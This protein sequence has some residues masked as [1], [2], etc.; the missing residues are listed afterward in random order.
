MAWFFMP[1]GT[2]RGEDI[3]RRVFIGLLIL[4]TACKKRD[5]VTTE[6]DP[7]DGT[8]TSSSRYFKRI[9]AAGSSI[10]EDNK[11]A[12]TTFV[13]NA[14]EH[15]Y[16]NN[17]LDIGPFAG[18]DLT[19]ALVKLKAAP[20]I[21]YALANRGFTPAD[22]SVTGG[23]KGATNK[24]LVTGVNFSTINGGLKGLGG[25]SFYTLYP[26]KYSPSIG[27]L[28][29]AQPYVL[30]MTGAQATTYWGMEASLINP[31]FGFE[32]AGAEGFYHTIRQSPTSTKSFFNGEVQSSST[33]FLNTSRNGN[34]E[35]MMGSEINGGFY[36]IDNGQLTDE[37]CKYFFDDV[38][39]LM[40]S[41]GRKKKLSTPINY[42]LLIGQSLAYGT[43]GEP[44]LTT[45]QPYNNK[46]LEGVALNALVPLV[47]DQME[48][49]ASPT[50]N[51]LS[52]MVRK[53]TNSG[54]N[55]QDLAI[56]NFAVGGA[57]YESLKKGTEPY[58]NSIAAVKGARKAAL[59][60]YGTTLQ[61][62]ALLVV[63]G[64]TDLNN[65]HYAADMEQWRSDYQAD[66]NAITGSSNTLKM[67]HSQTDAWTAV[68]GVS[69]HFSAFMQLELHE[70]DTNHIL[71]GPKY[72]LPHNADGTH[73]INT[74]YRTLGEYYA[75]AWYKQIVLRQ[76]YEP[77]RPVKAVLK[78]NTIEVT[79]TGNVGNLVLDESLVSNPG[80]YGFEYYDEAG[81]ATISSVTV[82]GSNTV[83]VMLNTPPTGAGKRI[84]YAYTGIPG[85]P[86]G[87]TTGPRGNLRDSDPAT[88]IYTGKN[89]YNWCV[90]FDKAI[91]EQ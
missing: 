60:Q 5:I 71:V 42:T 13:V 39:Q 47:E 23:L 3:M 72:F 74:S 55:L 35:V 7:V 32:N 61:V 17:L 54:N 58:T 87:P 41:L 76:K 70:A 64:E 20:G 78:G 83:K 63:H 36:A 19:A 15:G 62:P 10:S 26:G 9:A 33:A 51:A 43:G 86:G 28:N 30:L 34:I 45:T 49:I 80:N 12:I 53:A 38:S 40:I 6:P 8:D 73:L 75:K 77:V 90:H 65:Q 88:S 84:R 11:A 2:D 37:Q 56:S 24:S 52:A 66:I 25:I 69:G 85:N 59:E 46:R 81:S 91:T 57:A 79:F 31:G 14:K 22:Y 1:T 21:T 89:L 44:A 68:N 16:W 18:N 82:S 50:A 27:L 4:F 29:T 48:T 67:F